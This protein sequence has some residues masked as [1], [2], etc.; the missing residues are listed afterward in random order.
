MCC[1]LGFRQLKHNYDD[2]D[3]SFR[4]LLLAHAFSA[5]SDTEMEMNEE[6]GGEA[7][8]QDDEEKCLIWFDRQFSLPS[9]APVPWQKSEMKF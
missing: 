4:L 6:R 9:S 1:A 2:G 3:I 7:Q 8:Q 5:S